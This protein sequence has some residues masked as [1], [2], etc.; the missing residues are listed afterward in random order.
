MDDNVSAVCAA[1]LYHGHGQCTY[2]VCTCACHFEQFV[3][4]QISR[5]DVWFAYRERVRERYYRRFG[6]RIEEA[7]L[8][9]PRLFRLEKSLM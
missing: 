4:D 6:A 2:P 1:N 9:T 7:R 3:L 8:E 5:G